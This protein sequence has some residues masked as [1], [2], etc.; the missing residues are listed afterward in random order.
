MEN[1]DLENIDKFNDYAFRE[2]EY[3]ENFSFPDGTKRLGEGVFWNCIRLKKVGIPSSVTSIGKRAFYGCESIEEII[4]PESIESIEEGAFYG[5]SSLKRIN[6]PKNIK[7]IKAS[8]FYQCKSLEMIEL[9][10]LVEKI[11]E[12]AFAY[13]SKLTE[14]KLPSFIER[15]EDRVFFGCER[16][17]II[18]FPKLLSH[19][20]KS[21]FGRLLSI[22]SLKL[23][24]F[25]KDIDDNAFTSC[26]KLESIIFPKY[27]EKIGDGAFSFCKSLKLFTLPDALI[28]IGSNVFEENT[29]K[30]LTIPR[31]VSKIG[32]S[33]IKDIDELVIYDTLLNSGYSMNIP[34]AV[35]WKK[36]H[37]ITVKASSDDKVLFRLWMTDVYVNGWNDN[38][39]Y[40]KIL[41]KE[42]FNFGLL[43]VFYKQYEGRTNMIKNSLMRLEYPILLSDSSKEMY[44]NYIKSVGD[45]LLYEFID[46]GDL[47]A[48]VLISKYGTITEN[49]IDEIIDYASTRSKKNV[50][51]IAFLMNFK[52]DSGFHDD[53]F[54]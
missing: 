19:I 46:T 5:C 4:L 3:V 34:E 37:Y 47:S 40:Q 49:N 51:I 32:T 21:A 11:G 43:D 22:K 15:I 42:G 38:F 23:P 7:E 29:L 33:L 54:I 10:K 8:T 20:G 6:I 2:N 50:Q 27:L 39:I 25:I 35:S 52:K 44:L 18:E 48:L 30:T 45:E 53:L 36:G 17:S 16:L 24:D 12:A 1:L 14:I 28:E 9:P 26:E 13:C 41:W 31:F